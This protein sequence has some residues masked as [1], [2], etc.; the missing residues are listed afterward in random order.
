MN[1]H[2]EY[3]ELIGKYADGTASAEE[4][5]RLE[6]AVRDDATVRELLLDYLY[7]DVAIEAVA[8][9]RCGVGGD[10]KE[11]AT[12]EAVPQSIVMKSINQR[13]RWALAA[14]VALAASLLLAVFLWQG[15]QSSPAYAA[16]SR[17]IEVAREPIDRVYRIRATERHPNQASTPVFSG[18]GGR[19]PGIDGAE[20]CVRGSDMF[21]LT[22]YFGNGTKHVAGSDGE[23]GWAAPPEGHVHLSRDIRR[24]RRAV[25][26]EHEDIPFIDLNADLQELAK[27]YELQLVTTDTGDESTRGWSRLAAVRLSAEIDGPERVDIWFDANGVAQRIQLTGLPRFEGSPRSVMLELIGQRDLGPSFFTHQQHH[28]ADRPIDWE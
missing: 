22:R 14:V 6:Q 23:L 28:A 15:P 2:H 3:L 1:P 18:E 19:K 8:A 5:S 7:L 4:V 25:P 11:L 26:G 21:V 16:L 17:V 24:F 10:S 20:L 13:R 9:G 12:P 27:G